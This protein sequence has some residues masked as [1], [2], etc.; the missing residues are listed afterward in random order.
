MREKRRGRIEEKLE[1][2]ARGLQCRITDPQGQLDQEKLTCCSQA[3]ENQ[4]ELHGV[5][6]WTSLCCENKCCRI[7]TLLYTCLMDLSSQL[8]V[9]PDCF[10]PGLVSAHIN[11]VTLSRQGGNK[12]TAGSWVTG[13][14]ISRI[15]DKG[16]DPIL[17]LRKTTYVALLWFLCIQSVNR[18]LFQPCRTSK[19][20]LRHLD[21]GLK[22]SVG[23]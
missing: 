11:L 9:S 8:K 18:M 13:A 6:G 19:K 4:E 21:S 20:P 12:T 2:K 23:N 10:F 1:W 16:P 15:K 14:C 5:S 22:S 3:G 7:L 17:C